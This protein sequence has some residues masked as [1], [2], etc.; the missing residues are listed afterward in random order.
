MWGYPVK[1]HPHSMH[2]AWDKKGSSTKVSSPSTPGNT[3]LEG[4]IGHKH[5][6]NNKKIPT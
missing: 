1:T 4:F 2:P 5:R 6:K 3:T